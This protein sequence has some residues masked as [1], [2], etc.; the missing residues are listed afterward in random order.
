MKKIVIIA[1]KKSHGP[2]D[3]GV[4]DYPA[5]A[6]LLAC[7]LK[8]ALGD[9]VETTLAYDDHWPSAAIAAADC[10]AVLSDGKD[11]DKPFATASQLSTPERRA[12]VDALCA[13]GG[14]L[15]VFHFSLFAPENLE[16]WMLERCGGCFSWEQDGQR[17]WHSRISWAKGHLDMALDHDLLRGFDGAPLHEEYY[18]R[19]RFDPAVTPLVIQRALEGTGD[20]QHVAWCL[21]RSDGG[22][23]FGTSMGHSLDSFRHHGLRTLALNAIAW[24]AGIEVPEG[25]LRVPFAE[26]DEVAAELD[27]T[28][29]APIRVAVL[30]GNA[31]HRWHNWVESTG[32]LV[33]AWG[34]DS[35]VTA[36]VHTD[37]ADLATALEDRDVLVLNWV[38]WED[39]AGMPAAAKAGILA[40]LERGGG[41]FVHHFAGGACHPSLRGAAASD[42]PE[43]R[44]FVRR[45]WEHRDIAPGPSGHDRYGSFTCVANGQHPLTAGLGRFE[46]EDEL[47]FRQHGEAPIEPLMHAR[48]NRT[49]ADEPLLWTYDHGQARVVQCLLGHSAKTYETPQA[50]VLAR[51]IVAWCARRAL[52]G[53][54][55]GP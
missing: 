40:F 43:Y 36:R 28:A 16:P 33:K 11:G 55:D 20:E 53:P 52:H 34:D 51:R 30:A 29:I 44:R 18:H 38:N 4:H 27:G 10:L 25:G 22:R 17:D 54:A 15:A 14:G 21:E 45:V 31:A 37:P 42:W 7:C 24:C 6:R 49:G 12:E 5:Q 23:S 8:R 26:R 19:L 50:R 13:R 1:G 46:V 39:P 3:N 9:A 35:R 48:S 2:D 32:A 41:L 47:Y